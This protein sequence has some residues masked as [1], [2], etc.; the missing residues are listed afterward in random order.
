MLYRSVRD[1]ITGI[2]CYCNTQLRLVIGDPE[3]QAQRTGNLEAIDTDSLARLLIRL[4][5][6][7]NIYFYEAYD[8]DEGISGHI[9]C[10]TMIKKYESYV[11]YIN[12]RGGG[13]P[14]I[15]DI[16][17]Y[18]QDLKEFKEKLNEYLDGIDNFK[19]YV[20]IDSSLV[21]RRVCDE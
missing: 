5:P 21:E 2:W 6:G 9:F 1:E 18:D 12:C 14:F 4:N 8:D 10:A 17:V 3:E 13:L 16:T 19:D 15:F 7:D 11:I 20:Y